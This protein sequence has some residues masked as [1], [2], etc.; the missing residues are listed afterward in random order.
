MWLFQQLG[1]FAP[2][3]RAEEKVTLEADLDQIEDTLSLAGR[4]S[5]ELG[6]VQLRLKASQ[7]LFLDISDAGKARHA[8]IANEATTLSF[9]VGR[10]FLSSKSQY[11]RLAIEVDHFL[12]SGANFWGILVHTGTLD[13]PESPWTVGFSLQ[14]RFGF[15][16]PESNLILDAST[17]RVLWTTP[18]SKLRLGGGISWAQR[19][20]DGPGLTPTEHAVLTLGPVASWET[21][22]GELKVRLG[23]RL[24]LDRDTPL[25]TAYLSEFDLPAITASW[26]YRL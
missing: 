10:Q 21:L 6:P 13:T 23:F 8:L 1:R 9:E 4:G 19:L 3:R 26:V 5:I 20:K 12:P 7:R 15:L 16:P 24:W 18:T 17:E 11:G 2:P 22:L 25:T 14:I